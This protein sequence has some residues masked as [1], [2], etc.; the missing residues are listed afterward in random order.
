MGLTTFWPLSQKP[1][2]GHPRNDHLKA[3]SLRLPAFSISRLKFAMQRATLLRH[4]GW[5]T[6]S[7]H[8]TGA[9]RMGALSAALQFHA[10]N[11]PDD[12]RPN[13]RQNGQPKTT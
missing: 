7:A 8:H 2:I 13:C 1:Q 3:I 10:C 4:R 11:P 12:L 9:A 6:G 5:G